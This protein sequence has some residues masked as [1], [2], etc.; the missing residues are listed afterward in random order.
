MENANEILTVAIRCHSTE[1]ATGRHSHNI[2]DD[3]LV[4]NS[5]LTVWPAVYEAVGNI[6]IA[7]L[8]QNSS[9]FQ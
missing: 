4:L 8:A 7:F 2:V 5:C 6:Q 3:W 9:S 1:V